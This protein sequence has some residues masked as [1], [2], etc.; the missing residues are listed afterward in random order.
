MSP[1]SPRMQELVPR[2][3]PPL[4]GAISRAPH[5]SQ[6]EPSELPVGENGRPGLPGDLGLPWDHSRSSHRSRCPVAGAGVDW[7]HHTGPAIG[8]E[9]PTG[10]SLGARWPCPVT[11]R[12]DRC[13]GCAPV[14]GPGKPAC[15][16]SVGAA[17]WGWQA[18]QAVP[19]TLPVEHLSPFPAVRQPRD[20]RC[21]PCLQCLARCRAG[22]AG[23][24]ALGPL[25]SQRIPRWAPPSTT[26]QIPQLTRQLV[27]SELSTP[28]SGCGR[29]CRTWLC[30][31]LDAVG[32]QLPV[33]LLRQWPPGPQP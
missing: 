12:G 5:A 19:S 13:S 15:P 25:G 3:Q 1:V 26:S 21:A 18:R 10:G 28:G 7:E 22:Q 17:C 23:T 16:L 20:L 2:D 30:G 9:R 11:A 8:A 24:R 6:T 32:Q 33:F 29:L 27:P 4:Y 31:A 14:L